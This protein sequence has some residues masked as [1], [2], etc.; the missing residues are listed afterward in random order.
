M[1]RT[2]GGETPRLSAQARLVVGSL[3]SSGIFISGV[4]LQNAGPGICETTS[5]AKRFNSKAQGR[6]AHPG[7][8]NRQS[9]SRTARRCHNE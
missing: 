8:A 7:F 4:Y 6:A 2:V 9:F 1:P 5:T 3:L